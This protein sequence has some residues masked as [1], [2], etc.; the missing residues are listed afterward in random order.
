MNIYLSYLYFLFSKRQASNPIND[1]KHE[2]V[3]E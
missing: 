3:A 1:T 2:S